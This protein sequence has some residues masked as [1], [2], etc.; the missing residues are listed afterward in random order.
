LGLFAATQT[1]LYKAKP[2][3]VP[4][5][6]TTIRRRMLYSFM[7]VGEPDRNV[8]YIDYRRRRPEGLEAARARLIAA[9]VTDI[10]GP[11]LAAAGN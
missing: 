2:M 5:D 3:V 1:L 6:P 10:R 9:T 7:H 11:F 4:L 8:V